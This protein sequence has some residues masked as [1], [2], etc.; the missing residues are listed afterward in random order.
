VRPEHLGGGG[1]LPGQTADGLVCVA[2][3]V[4]GYAVLSGLSP[5][6]T[7]AILALAAGGILAMLADTMFPEALQHGGPLLA[8][9]TAV[10]FTCALLLSELAG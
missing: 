4:A 10:G 3:T 9:A 7:S 2:A 1:R 6:M 8:L 5:G